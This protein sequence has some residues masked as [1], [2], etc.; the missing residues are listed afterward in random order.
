[1]RYFNV[2]ALLSFPVFSGES[3]LVV[4][5]HQSS[6]MK[7]ICSG[8][9]SSKRKTSSSSAEVRI[10]EVNTV[11]EVSERQ[12]VKRREKQVYAEDGIEDAK[13]AIVTT[14]Q[15]L[16]SK[17]AEVSGASFWIYLFIYWKT[18]VNLLYSYV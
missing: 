2:Y 8:K 7:L 10:Q 13:T 1:M 5:D 14:L 3:S 6:E 4:E 17:T 16:S 18:V 15:K 11:L 12:C 9:K